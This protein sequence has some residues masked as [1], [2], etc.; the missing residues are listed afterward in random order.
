MRFASCA[1]AMLLCASPVS[2]QEA[3]PSKPVSLVI[4]A[5]PGGNFHLSGRIVGDRLR[6]VFDKPFLND[7]KPGAGGMIAA[8]FVAKAEPDGHTL[9]VSGNLLLFSP[10]ILGQARYDWKRDLAIVG[11][12]SFTPMVLEV[13]PSVKAASVRDLL[14]LAKRP[15]SKLSMSAPGAGTTNHLA[16]ELLQKLTG[17]RWLTV[18]YKGNAPAV[19][20]LIGGHV[21]FAFDQ[22]SSSIGHIRNG[23]VRA[24]AVTSA[25]RTSALPDVPTMQE[26]GVPGVEAET[27]AGLFAPAKTPPAVLERAGAAL[28]RALEEPAVMEQFRNLGSELRPMSAAQFDQYLRKLED[29][30]VPLIREANIKAN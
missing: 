11:A 3:W 23:S 19:A 13:H 12:I 4:P 29:T 16:S 15:G 26:A 24:L 27:F 21:D 25:R 17:A 10:L 5:P 1:A 14:D 30:W 2:A 18:H 7:N 22:I 6:Q 28:A 8:E 20:D 9:L